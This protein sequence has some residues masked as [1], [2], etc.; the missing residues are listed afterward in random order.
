[1]SKFRFLLTFLAL[2]SAPYTLRSQ[3]APTRSFITG[4]ELG[5]SAEGG[6]NGGSIQSAVV[7]SGSYAY[8]ANPVYSNQYIA[9]ASRA[10]GGT[11]RSI[12]RS[13]RF[14]LRIA[15][16][17]YGSVSIVKIG[18][19]ATFNPEVDLN[20][21]GTLTLADS[22]YPVLAKSQQALT[23]NVWHR[24][25]FDVGYGLRVY[26][27]GA[28]WA[29]GGTTTYPAAASILFGA[30]ASPTFVNSTCDLYF[31][32][33]LID[34]GSFA[35]TGLPGDGHAVLLRP[36]SDPLALNSWTGGAGATSNLWMPVH[37]VPLA[38][39]PPVSATDMSQ[40]KNR[41]HGSNLDYRPSVQSY[42]DAGI[43]STATINAVMALSNDGQ[44]SSKGQTKSGAIWIDKNPSQTAG[45]YSF[46]FG[47]NNG[48]ISSFPAGWATHYGPVSARPAVSLS[49]SPVVAVRKSSGSDV[50]VD[51]LGVYVD[52]Q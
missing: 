52:Y 8:R 28:L 37:N 51:F 13:S 45:G 1:M 43:P 39:K 7:R 3:T 49:A 34:S 2:I 10:S 29:S 38:G 46:D 32:D 30:G 40:I 31:D 5:P 35:T 48:A 21:D 16:L 25:E 6:A 18:G 50:D 19:A 14:Y 27:D 23:Q 9:F 33:I 4:F 17:P 15:Q 26:V 20:P 47:D 11:L 41:S 24:I 22:W 12:F 42:N 44:E 36:A